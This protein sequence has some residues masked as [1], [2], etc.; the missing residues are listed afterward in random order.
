MTAP[1]VGVG[2]RTA[3]KAARPGPAPTAL[4]AWTV[5]R[6]RVPVRTPVGAVKVVP[7]APALAMITMGVPVAAPR[8]SRRCAVT[9]YPVSR[10][11]P[12]VAGLGHHDAA[13]RRATVGP[14]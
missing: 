9:R 10:E 1:V 11:P 14:R 5:N 2:Q 13:E 7:W 3:V 4:T 6:Y 8:E 12:V